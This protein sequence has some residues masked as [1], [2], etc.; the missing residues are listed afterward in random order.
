M[1]DF[2]IAG[3]LESWHFR[4]LQFPT[5]Y[6]IGIYFDVEVISKKHQ[7]LT[8]TICKFNSIWI[9][10]SMS[11]TRD[12][13]SRFWSLDQQLRSVQNPSV[14]PFN[15]GWLRGFIPVLGKLYTLQQV[16]LDPAK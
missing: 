9:D 2:P 1:R 14:S 10:I 16:N 3:E 4:F 15:P 6:I 8:K 13:D 12:F 7:M 5:V 11:G